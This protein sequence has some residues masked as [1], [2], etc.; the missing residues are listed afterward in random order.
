[1]GKI[2]QFADG[3]YG[4]RKRTFDMLYGFVNEFLSMATPYRD[5]YPE[6]A[7]CSSK[8]EEVPEYCKAKS[9]EQVLAQIKKRENYFNEKHRLKDHGAVVAGQSIGTFI[10][11]VGS[12]LSEQKR[13]LL[14]RYSKRRRNVSSDN[15]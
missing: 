14:E 2:V 9:V 11:A 6:F 4:Y 15:V 7:T 13:R 5:E 3:Q 1:M 10:R 8:K 12:E